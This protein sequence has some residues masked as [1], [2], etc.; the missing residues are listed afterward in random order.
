MQTKYKCNNKNSN[1]SNYSERKEE[2]REQLALA[3]EEV[4]ANAEC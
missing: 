3:R 2:K 1:R 4:A